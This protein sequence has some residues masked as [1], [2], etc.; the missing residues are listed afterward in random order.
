M[1]LAPTRVRDARD[2]PESLRYR[3]VRPVISPRARGLS[4]RLNLNPDGRCNFDCLYCDVRRSCLAGRPG[5][6]EI[7]E[8]AQ[9]L[10]EV[11][12][13]I[14]AGEGHRLHGCESAPREFLGL[15]HVALS[16]D[17]EPTLCPGFDQ[18]VEQV[19]HLRA[20]GRHGFFKV[21]L[22]TN[23]SG[24]DI[25]GV[26]RGL[27]LLTPQD[28]IWTKL[29]AGSEAWFRRVNRSNE[30]FGRVLDAMVRVGRSRPLVIQS[31]FPRLE[32]RAMPL[33]EQ[34]AYARQLRMLVDDGAQVRMVQVYS[35][36]RTPAR[37][38]CGHASLAELSGIA[39]RVREVV[40][41]PAQ[42]F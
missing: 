38:G 10:E 12:D 9:E 6:P 26:R 29:D 17:G 36:S 19:L 1:N 2:A 33:A 35:A 18:V 32:G 39:R 25:P 4:V 14:R 27:S 5:C 13:V 24:F 16:G 21:A 40:G 22:I 42:V 7:D 11:L 31:L 3:Y 34:D 37:S 8:M 30:E 41:V 28:E 23:G 20:Q 15:G